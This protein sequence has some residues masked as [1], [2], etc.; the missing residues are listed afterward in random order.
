MRTRWAATIGVALLLV[1]AGCT[2]AQQR[3]D[4]IDDSLRE[5]PGVIDL[6]ISSTEKGINQTSS[7]VV[8]AVVDPESSAEQIAEVVEAWHAQSD[9]EGIRHSLSIEQGDID[10]ML[11][12][13]RGVVPLENMTAFAAQWRALVPHSRVVIASMTADSSSTRIEWPAAASPVAMRP[14]VEDIRKIIAG[15][16]APGKWMITSNDEVGAEQVLAVIS[17]D[18]PNDEQLQYLEFLTD[19]FAGAEQ[20]GEVALTVTFSDGPAQVEVNLTPDVFLT[21]PRT[22][23]P[24]QLLTSEVWPVIEQFTAAAVQTRVSTL[25]VSVFGAPMAAL[26]VES[27]ERPAKERFPLDFEVW[28]YWASINPVCFQ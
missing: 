3:A 1:L 23:V 16:E 22:Q 5:L 4:A 26:D 6:R 21:T 2:P 12:F 19:G 28:D 27:C 14:A 9:G 11:F 15:V 10:H 7:V 8:S 20:I 25:K 17:D 24:D 18:L 13:D